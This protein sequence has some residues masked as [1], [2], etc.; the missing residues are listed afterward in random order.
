M[1]KIL[2]LIIAV[3]LVATL[4]F[5]VSM[6]VSATDTDPAIVVSSATTN[7]GGTVDVKISLKNNPGIA[8]LNLKVKFSNDLS[9]VSSGEDTYDGKYIVA[10]P[11]KNGGPEFKFFDDQGNLITEPTTVT[12][13]VKYDVV[14]IKGYAYQPRVGDT[15]F[16]NIPEENKTS[17]T[18]NWL[19][20]TENVTGDFTFATLK[21]K[22]A[23]DAELGDK[24]ITVTYA[25]ED[26]YNSDESNVAFEVQNGKI[27]VTDIIKGDVDGDGEVTSDDAILLLRYSLLPDMYEINQDGD[28]DHD[29]D[30]TSDDAILLLRHSLLPD[31]YPLD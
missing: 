21:F 13:W 15:S 20:P 2:A 25:A 27:T 18:L 6:M 23:D 7:K 12:N 19:S 5:G 1:K 29:G 10:A 3:I 4:S 9:L 22:V 16:K 8:S 26:V 28:F 30:V 24:D 14:D 17:L 11:Q 31:M